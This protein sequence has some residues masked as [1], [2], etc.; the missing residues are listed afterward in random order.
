VILKFHFSLQT[1][2]YGLQKNQECLDQLEKRPFY[3]HFI[4]LLKFMLALLKFNFKY[5][6]CV[7]SNT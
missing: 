5:D 1:L 6:L 7:P 3:V 4:F 2:S